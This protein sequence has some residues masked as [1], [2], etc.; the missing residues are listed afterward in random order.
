MWHSCVLFLCNTAWIEDSAVKDGSRF[1]TPNHFLFFL[2]FVFFFLVASLSSASSQSAQR[3]SLRENLEHSW[4]ER[5]RP[6]RPRRR[7][8][9]S[10]VISRSSQIIPRLCCELRASHSC[11]FSLPSTSTVWWGRS[12]R[13]LWV[14]KLY[15]NPGRVTWD[16][17]PNFPRHHYS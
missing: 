17:F 3:E 6:R 1:L 10:K 9:G 15:E 5:P 12:Y 14:A 7:P 8:P 4:R 16:K 13:N 11:W 2:F